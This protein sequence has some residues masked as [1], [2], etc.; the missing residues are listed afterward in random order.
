MV[1]ATAAELMP[2]PGSHATA[3]PTATTPNTAATATRRPRG[4]RQ[5]LLYA[6]MKGS[7]PLT[8]AAR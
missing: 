1:Y 8:G 6:P 5:I 3:P 4:P 7:L 2:L